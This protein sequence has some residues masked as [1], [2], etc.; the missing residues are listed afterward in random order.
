M[1]PCSLRLDKDLL[2]KRP[3]LG[4]L[5]LYSKNQSAT[6]S[7]FKNC[8]KQL[9]VGMEYII[10]RKPSMLVNTSQF[11]LAGVARAIERGV[12][13][14][15]LAQLLVLTSTRQTAVP[16]NFSQQDVVHCW[17]QQVPFPRC[18][19]WYLQWSKIVELWGFFAARLPAILSEGFYVVGRWYWW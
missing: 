4:R 17:Q 14:R 11:I 9:V 16:V 3:Y 13:Q 12:T 10:R 2:R 7:M 18:M 8:C 15:A 1:N 6:T 19:I 5:G